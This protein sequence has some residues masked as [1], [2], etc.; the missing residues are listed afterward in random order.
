MINYGLTCLSFPET[1]TVAINA[2]SSSVGTGK[3]LSPL[4]K[5]INNNYFIIGEYE[6]IEQDNQMA[7][8][9]CLQ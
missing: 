5:I 8:Q 2:K 9:C 6:R 1:V 4:L 3:L 7:I